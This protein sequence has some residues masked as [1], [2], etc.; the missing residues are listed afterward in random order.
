MRQLGGRAVVWGAALALG[1][2]AVAFAGAAVGQSAPDF[3]LADT[4][5]QT[6]SLSQWK[7]KVV[8][9]EW[10]NHECPFVG[11]HY[12][13]GNM[14]RLQATATAQGMVWVTI[15][16][17]A[18]GKQGHVSPDQ[19]DAL[20]KDRGASP[21]AVLLDPDGTVGRRYGA[22]TT[23]HMFIIDASGV[24]A[25][26]GAIDDKPSADR[27]DLARAT[28]YVQRALDELLAGR[29]VSIRSTKPYGCSVKY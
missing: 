28:N 14:Q 26:A 20:T 21:T 15:I 24:L 22:K 23:P 8:V 3:T 18:P 12:A 13:S 11:K 25:Y 7:G 27:A 9:L 1:G 6:R 2:G 5:G 17:S 29:P 19:A 16:S 10:S 4:T